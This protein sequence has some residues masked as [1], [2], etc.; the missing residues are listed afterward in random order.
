MPL[1]PIWA[2][3]MKHAHNISWK[4]TSTRHSLNT[5][6]GLEIDG[7]LSRWGST[8]QSAT[9]HTRKGCAPQP[10]VVVVVGAA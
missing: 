1:Q 3:C 8:P 9:M 5:S 7:D 4:N 2:S 6:G 10:L